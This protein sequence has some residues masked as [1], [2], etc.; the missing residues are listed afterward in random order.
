L[1][2]SQQGKITQNRTG[3]KFDSPKCCPDAL[4]RIALES[5]L[6][7]QW[8]KLSGHDVMDESSIAELEAVEQQIMDTTKNEK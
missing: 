1:S 2:A 5:F 4:H 7:A 6:I 3:S 8:Q